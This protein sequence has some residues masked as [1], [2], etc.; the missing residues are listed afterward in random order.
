MTRDVWKKVLVGLLVG[1]PIVFFIV[2][3]FLITVSGEDI[4]Q[5][6]GTAPDVWKDLR[7]AFLHNARIPDMY[8]W[9]V[10]NFFDYQ[11]RFG[12]DTIFRLIDVLLGVGML[13]LMTRVAVGKS[14]GMKKKGERTGMTLGTAMLWALAFI[15]MFLTPH[16]RVLYA[17]F[18]AI[19][20]YLLIV[21]ISL[22]FGW[23]YLKWVRGED[24]CEQWWKVVL[25]LG[26]GVVFG[27]S[28][29]LTPIAFLITVVGFVVVEM[30][31]KRK[32]RE[33][34]GKLPRWGI[35]GV[36][37]VVLGMGVAY[38]YGP[39]VSGYLE[40]GYTE[41]YD[42]VS[43]EDLRKEPGRS[44]VKI[45]KHTVRNFVRV[46]GPVLG[47][48]VVVAV[49]A[50]LVRRDE[51]KWWPEENGTRRV[52]KGLIA[53]V[54]V[55]VVI[56][57]QLDVPLRILLPAYVG[58]VMVLMILV[59]EWSVGWNARW[60]VCVGLG[61]AV[62]TLG[63]VGMRMVLAVE[64]RE[65]AGKVLEKIGAAEGEVV[66]VTREEVKSRVLP[67][68]YLGQEDMLAEWAM[69]AKVLGKEV[70]WCE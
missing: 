34:I 65:K 28:S 16:G 53:F 48:L 35:A 9:A 40:S 15:M 67:V 3:Y 12:I 24:D 42:Y 23:W 49:V 25:M 56:A 1:L 57:A 61:L 52:L 66:C 19:H 60:E 31:R 4:F 63:V 43:F 68:I 45:A 59:K 10:I 46:F 41:E 21:M 51:V 18:S 20:N 7:E 2:S 37:G 30:V 64:Y 17:G 62:V 50:W 27:L 55:H 8:A 39:G 26:F 11:Y 13:V 36:I 69:P 22:G 6:A 54:I 70:V 44:A 29:N 58:A 33:V 14:W 38:I 5:G 47:V 32:I